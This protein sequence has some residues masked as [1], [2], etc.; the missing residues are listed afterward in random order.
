MKTVPVNASRSYMIHIADDILSSA[1]ELLKAVTKAEKVAVISDSNVF[2]L[3]GKVLSDSLNR[4]GFQ[5][6]SYVFPA[7]EQSKNGNTYLEILNFLAENQLTRSD[8]LVALGGG[9]VGDLTGFA[10]ATYLRGIAYVQ[11]P[12]TLLAM[13]DSSVYK[14]V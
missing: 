13:V 11:I 2:P 8:C 1:G 7:G 5:V 10:A 14:T 12:T 6:V 9:V 4:A 3:Y